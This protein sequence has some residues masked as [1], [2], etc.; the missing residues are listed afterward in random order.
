LWRNI[1]P[2]I[3]DRNQVIALDLPGFGQS[4]KPLDVSYS[5]RFYSEILDGFLA[6][7]NIEAVGL[8]VHD[9]G[10]PVGL[11][12]ACHHPERVSK[13]ALL[14][15][16]VYPKMSWAVVVFVA[17]CRIPGIRSLL[18][19][20]SGLRFGMKVGIHDPDKVTQEILDGVLA[21]F[22]TREARAA[23][24]KAGSGLHPS[25]FKDIARLLPSLTMP[26]RIVYGENDRI[27]PDVA[28]TMRHVARD[29]PQAQVTSL[30][31]CGHFLQEEKP[32]E[33]GEI[34]ADFFSTQ[35][36]PSSR[37]R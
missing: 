31:D 3:A 29:L 13:L 30:A 19:G 28:E 8:A 24:L 4:D 7:L 27:L 32:D 33:I 26:V 25:G 20:P 18:A 2:R 12:W 14:N 37:L 21:P 16:L 10:G 35:R 36:Q 23:L 34:L 22:V 11:H 5:F 1:A 15:T 6:A 9:L 17:A